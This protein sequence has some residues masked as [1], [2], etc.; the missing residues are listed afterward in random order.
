MSS[1]RASTVIVRRRRFLHRV[2]AFFIA[3]MLVPV[4]GAGSVTVTQGKLYRETLPNGM[5]VFVLENHRAPVVSLNIVVKVGSMYEDEH[6][7]GISHFFEHLFFRGTPRRTGEQFKR[8]IEALGGQTNAKT[9]KDLTHFYINLP[10]IYTRNGLDIL[11]DALEN[12]KLAPAEVD[13]ERKAVLQEYRIG[14]ES[15]GAILQN[16]LYALA[17]QKHPYRFP[18]IGTEKTIKGMTIQDFVDFKRRYYIPKR[19]TLIIVGDVTPADVMPA[20]REYFQPFVG[21]N[22]VT[23]DTPQEPKT[24][25][26]VHEK[27]VRRDLQNAF[28]VVG[29]K[30]P[31]VRDRPDIYR[32]DTMTFLIGQGEGS[33][34]TQ[35]LVEEKKIALAASAE[36]LTQRDP[37]LIMLQATCAPGRVEKVKQAILETVKQVREGRFSQA[38]FD[39][40]KALLVNTYKF[41]NE[42]NAGMADGFGFYAAIDNVEFAQSYLGEIHKV[43][44]Q[45][46][47]DA[48]RKYLD[49]KNYTVLVVRPPDRRA[50]ADPYAGTQ[51]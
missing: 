6:I 12:T 33:L 30:A 17:F 32:V 46:V 15:P 28:V 38:D 11:S 49:L 48:A 26:G 22:S 40:A 18:I 25:D 7:N 4:P 47:V 37:G 44:F 41:G 16:D 45:D 8:E 5:Q 19:T 31:S 1:L 39:R 9:T 14:M 34:I 13:E 35:Q 36:F 20:V 50:A 51:P 21:N 2:V 29:F 24:G 27:V 42:T 10:S 43:T 3:L 23:D